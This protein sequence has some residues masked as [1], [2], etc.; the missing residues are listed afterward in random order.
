[1]TILPLLYLI[2]NTVLFAV[3]W[4]NMQKD[5]SKDFAPIVT[6]I[7]AF[8]LYITLLEDMSVT[9]VALI[10]LAFAGKP[11]E[12][13]FED[14]QISDMIRSFKEQRTIVQDDPDYCLELEET[15]YE[16]AYVLS[17]KPETLSS[18][19]KDVAGVESKEP[20]VKP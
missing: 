15:I 5:D 10:K 16:L 4:K 11:N 14:N 12:F 8:A 1:M 7:I 13:D 19:L 2:F 18:L 6:V 17:L 3:H 9:A 20:E